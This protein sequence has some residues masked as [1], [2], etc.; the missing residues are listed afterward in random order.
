MVKMGQTGIRRVRF[1]PP[2]PGVRD[3]EV[4]TLRGIR[5]R[6]GPQEFLTSQRLDFDLLVHVA[7]GA[8]RHTVDFTDHDLAADDV[9]WVRAGQ[10]H[11]WGQ[12][13]AI[14]GTV[15][16]FAPHVVDERAR[17]VVR[18]ASVRTPN[19]WAA[20]DLTNT[21]V[22]GAIAVLADGAGPPD[23]ARSELRQVG[24]A[25]SLA[26]VLVQLALVD[27]TADAADER[28]THEVFA[29]FS[30]HIDE[31]FRGW[32]KV[33]QYAERLG[34]STRTLNRLA[35]EHTGRTAKELID[36]R[37][38]LEAKRL[39]SHGDSAVWELARELG[40]DDASNFSSYFRLRAGMTPV[41]FR[42]WSRG[43]GTARRATGPEVN[44]AAR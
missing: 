13:A 30:D 37:I 22:P 34:Y 38:V 14:E 23:A 21:P 6:G 33:S 2:G 17:E 1:L 35:R 7:S 41:E 42:E 11:R 26:A 40:F 25:H 10:V 9:L 16:L 5:E 28:A 36:E 24:L 44:P 4:N 8:T 20:A 15:V 3:I 31:H 18:A 12:I 39:L 29:W 19:H 43:R 27:P 32:H